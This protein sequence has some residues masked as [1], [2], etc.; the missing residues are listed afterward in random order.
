MS[1]NSP[2]PHESNNRAIG[3]LG[4]NSRIFQSGVI[5]VYNETQVMSNRLVTK[6]SYAVKKYF[7]RTEGACS[8]ATKVALYA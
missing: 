3:V 2:V 4:K 7:S 5:Q 8:F 6:S 1:A